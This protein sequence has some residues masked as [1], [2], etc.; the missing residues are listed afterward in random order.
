MDIGDATV[1]DP[2]L[3]AVKGPGVARLA[4][5]RSRGQP[6]H[7]RASVGLRDAEGGESDL[8]LCPKTLRN[9]LANLLGRAVGN[10]ARDSEDRAKQSERDARIAPGQLLAHRGEQ[11]AARIPEAV[12]DEVVGVQADRSGL[13]DDRP[14]GLLA[15][16]PLMGC[17]AKYS[18]REVVD[19]VDHLLLVFI[20][21]KGEHHGLLLASYAQ[22]SSLSEM[23]LL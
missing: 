5:D 8:L 1:G 6:A 19:P 14:G 23:L 2:G 22:L 10:D 13:L 3:R 12:G 17:L 7:V 16:V 15:F 11:L 21:L 9:P 4:V 18:S 20:E